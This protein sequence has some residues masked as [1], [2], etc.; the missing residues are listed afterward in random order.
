[1]DR[2]AAGEIQV[3]IVQDLDRLA[4]PEEAVVYTTIRQV[5]M[6]YNVIIHAHE[7]D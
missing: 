6:E 7:P 1:L 5:I 2:I 4:R 3:I